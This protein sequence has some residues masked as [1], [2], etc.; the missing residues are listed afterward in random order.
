MKKRC[1]E[2]QTMDGD[3]PHHLA[4]KQ[5]GHHWLEQPPLVSGHVG[6]VAHPDPV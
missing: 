1:A 5:V 2:E 3:Q 6:D 4:A